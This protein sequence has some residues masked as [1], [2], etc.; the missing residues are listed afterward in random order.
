MPPLPARVCAAFLLSAACAVA[1]AQRD[2]GRTTGGQLPQIEKDS[3]AGNVVA[4]VYDGKVA[5]VRIETRERNAPLNQHPVAIDAATLRALLMRIQLG[6]KP[7]RK[8]GDPLLG[9]AQLDE[10]VPPLAEAL[11]RATPEQD[12]SFAVSGQPGAIG[13]L[14]PRKVTTARVFYADNRLNLIFGLVRQ[15][16]ESRYRA[17]AYLIPF[18][19]GK[20]AA[21]VDRAV[22]VAAVGGEQRR[23]DWVQIDPFAPLPDVPSDAPAAPAVVIPS[24]TPAAPAA[25][26]ARAPATGP[27]TAAPAPAPAPSPPPANESDAAYRQV[28]ERLKT[29]QKLRDA[30]L[31]TEEEYQE[32]RREILKAL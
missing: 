32:K 31:L 4:M 15:D 28:A 10:I 8:A 13:L 19:P 11:G 30:G 22:R 5:Y 1:H 9:P 20:R 21:A 7:D 25:P 3:A 26:A 6:D 12:V 16:W 27:G 18:E 17:T 29:L 24:P 14:V 2:P 23:A